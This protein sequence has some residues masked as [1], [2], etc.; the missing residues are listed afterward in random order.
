M[1]VK[2]ETIEREVLV[3]VVNAPV[4][5]VV[6]PIG[7]GMAHVLPRSVVAF[8]VPIVVVPVTVKFPLTTVLPDPSI[9]KNG[10]PYNPSLSK[11]DVDAGPT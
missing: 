2:G 1:V 3:I 7:S 9:V 5:G 8:K 6:E 10:L 11:L 4:E